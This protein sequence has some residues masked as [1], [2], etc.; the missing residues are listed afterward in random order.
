[1][2]GEYMRTINNYD[3]NTKQT[4]FSELNNKNVVNA[5]ISGHQSM[6]IR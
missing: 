2:I 4:T 6:T 5:A 3:D 1:M